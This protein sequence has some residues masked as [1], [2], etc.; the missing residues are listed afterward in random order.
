MCNERVVSKG[1]SEI[2]I[3]ISVFFM[4]LFILFPLTLLV[5]EVAYYKIV[6][7]EI[8]V[9]VENASY[10]ALLEL[11][12]QSLTKGDLQPSKEMA[13][14]I[15]TKI[16]TVLKK[17]YS[18]EEMKITFESE[19]SRDCIHIE[20]KYLYETQFVFKGKLVKKMH[21]D[22]RYEIPINN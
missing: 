2:G 13:S 1:L 20:F 21:V 19:N 15:N 11:E 12:F 22:V 5:Q 14:Q 10:D 18:I 17:Q 9:V 3:V 8:R 16:K 4:L 7:N 6:S